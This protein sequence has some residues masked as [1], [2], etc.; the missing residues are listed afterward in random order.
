MKILAD[1]NIPFVRDAFSAFGEVAAV[2]GRDI[3]PTLV[4]NADI[5]LVRAVTRVDKNLLDA[6]SVSFVASPTSGIDHIDV[7]YLE[8]RG[9]GFAYAPGSNA[10]SV[11]EYVV[12]ALLELEPRIGPLSRKSLGIV[13]CGHVGSRVR[14]MGEALGMRCVLNDPPLERETGDSFYS[15]IE[16]VLGCDVVS[17]HVPLT[18]D[19]PDATYHLADEGFLRRMKPGPC[20]ST[21]RVARSSTAAR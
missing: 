13:G 18:H 8:T 2:T 4:R 21:H 7:E 3:S 1:E 5:L 12:A 19:G 9:I 15:P 16:D 20:W 10:N 17:L 6:S 11:A 14:A